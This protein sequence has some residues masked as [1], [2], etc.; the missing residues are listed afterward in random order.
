ML[1][2]ELNFGLSEWLN[3]EGDQADVIISSRI[4]LARN[5][6]KL[7]FPHWAHSKSS[8]PLSNGLA[9]TLLSGAICSMGRVYHAFAGPIKGFAGANE[10]QARWIRRTI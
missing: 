4:R 2:K 7:P 10:T 5:I 6:R 8:P 9:S 1:P 3:G